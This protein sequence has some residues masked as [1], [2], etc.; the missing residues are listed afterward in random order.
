MIK[1]NDFKPILKITILTAKIVKTSQFYPNPHLV[2]I[3]NWIKS[4]SEL[5][6]CIHKVRSSL[7]V[8]KHRDFISKDFI[9]SS[10]ILLLS[11]NQ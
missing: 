9:L 4:D 10:E 8:I 11:E 1:T 7:I 6:Q 3:S 2:T 5:S